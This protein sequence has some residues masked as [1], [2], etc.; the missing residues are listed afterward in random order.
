[1][2]RV[3]RRKKRRK[4]GYT[5]QHLRV[6]EHGFDFHDVYENK[7]QRLEAWEI[8][9]DEI[10]ADWIRKPRDSEHE[11]PGP[12]TRPWAWWEFDAPELRRR[13]NGVHPFD[14]PE[15]NEQIRELEKERPDSQRDAFKLYMGLPSILMIRDDFECD[16]ETQETYLRRLDLLM[17]EEIEML[18]AGE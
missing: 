4:L 14:N 11:Y 18:E 7:Q 2:P 13:L 3:R 15:R 10:I 8:F 9:R 17:P 6:L 12:G 5:P 16:Y 1:M